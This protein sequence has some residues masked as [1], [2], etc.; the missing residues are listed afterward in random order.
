MIKRKPTQNQTHG[1]LLCTLLVVMLILLGGI[2]VGLY[3]TYS[4]CSEIWHEQCR[5][6]DQEIDVIITTGKMVHPDVVTLQFG[7]TN[8]ANLA[9]IPFADLRLKLLKKVPNIRDLRIERRLP[10]HV[11]VDVIEREPLARIGPSKGNSND[12]RVA[13]SEGVVFQYNAN[14]TALLPIVREPA[15]ASATQTGEKLTGA[16]AA[17]LRLIEVAGQPEFAELRVREI[18]T[19]HTDYLYLTLGNY[20]HSV[21]AW[22]DMMSDTKVARE[23]LQQQLRRLSQAINTRLTPS[24]TVWIANNWESKTITASN[25]N[26]RALK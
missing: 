7:L 5:V 24:S 22:K 13:D 18:D 3:Y 14:S 1:G 16:T 12:G 11:T 8:G 23:S 21:F 2:S 17:A 26:N 9:T 4:F 10:N 25:A 6:S 19:S 20:D 15:N